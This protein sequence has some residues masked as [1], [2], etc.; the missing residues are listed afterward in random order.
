MYVKIAAIAAITIIE[1]VALYKGMNGKIMSLAVG[2]LG[3]IAGYT[4][5][6]T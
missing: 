5:G 4:I 1:C 2:V 3:G 6:V